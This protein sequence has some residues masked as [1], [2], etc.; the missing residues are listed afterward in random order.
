MPDSLPVLVVGAGISGLICAYALR[1]AGVD[2]HLYEASSQAGGL[3]QS[4]RQ[5]GFLLELGPQSF[6]PTPAIRQ[7]CAELAIQDEIVEAPA[8]A[9]RFV[10]HQGRLEQVPLGPQTFFLSSFV[11]LGTKWT[12][13]RDLLGK[14]SPPS[15]EESIATFVRRK[16]SA[17]LLQKLVGPFVSGIYAGD[18]EKLSLRASFPQL[19]QA[20]T[21]AGSVIRGTIRAAKRNRQSGQSQTRTIENF[22]GGTQTLVKN[23]KDNLGNALH[24]SAPITGLEPA[25]GG[26][27]ITARVDGAA[28]VLRAENVVLALPTNAA[29]SLLAADSPDLGSILEEIEYAPIAVVS[30]GYRLSDVGHDLQGFGFLVPRSAGLQILGSVWN[31]SLFPGRAPDGYSLI[32]SFVG[33]ATNPAAVQLGDALVN[34][35]HAELTPVLRISTPPVFSRVTSYE[36]AIPQYN[37][38]HLARVKALEKG[39][40]QIPGLFLTGNYLHGPSVGACVEQAQTV[41]AAV[42]KR[43]KS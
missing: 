2:A 30:L 18:P 32:T 1:R 17:D 21:E 29:A 37:L 4:E 31:S 16:F 43:L 6:T 41:A 8:K 20:E 15:E 35:V 12:I 10:F 34:P 42:L 14:S 3:I 25:K 11:G 28:R 7:L 38:G 40:A 19:H 36:R 5:D 22:R 27:T 13:L 9:P 26:F 23:L 24:L 33:G 39:S